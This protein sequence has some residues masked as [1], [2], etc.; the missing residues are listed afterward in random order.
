MRQD[1]SHDFRERPTGGRK[2]TTSG[3]T[4]RRFNGNN[5][6]NL[7]GSIEAGATKH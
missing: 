6:V 5:G 4:V 3:A 2:E 7:S 1:F